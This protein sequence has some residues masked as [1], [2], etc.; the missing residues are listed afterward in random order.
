MNSI[1]RDAR[2]DSTLALLREGY[3]FISNGCRRYGSDIFET[4]LMLARAYCVLGE[5]AARMFYE[6]GR[7]TRRGAIP[8]TTLGLLQDRGSVATLDHGPHHHRKELFLSMMGPEAVEGMAEIFEAEWRSRL[9]CWHSR[10]EIIFFDEMTS[11]VTRSVCAW[12]GIPLGEREASSRVRE[13]AAMIDGAGSVGP[14]NWR[15]QWHRRRTERWAREIV[16]S[17]R[18]GQLDAPQGSALSL[19]TQHRDENGAPLQ[20]EIAAVELINVL[21][22]TVAVDRFITFAALA[23]HQHPHSRPFV[24]AGNEE[25]LQ[26]FAQEVRRFYPFF[27]VVGGRALAGFEWRDHLFSPGDWVL[28]DLYGTNRDPRIWTDPD[29]FRPERFLGREPGAFQL[30]SQGGG[31]HRSGHRCPG[32]WIT[33]A[34][35]KRAASLLATAMTYEVPDQDLTVRI[36]RFPTLPRSKFVISNVRA[37]G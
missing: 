35:I 1:P 24:Q 31:D 9:P 18:T 3:E 12:A 34:L 17:V 6:P 23:L 19:I 5:E 8:R 14:R 33:L 32:E 36:D 2:F 22:P 11:I 27:P 13:F 29:T 30:I 21:R 20:D 10:G 16:S 15:A 37:R 28:L 26:A 25:A 7:F 4:R